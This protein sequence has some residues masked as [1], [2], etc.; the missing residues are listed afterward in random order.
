MPP[1]RNPIASLPY[2]AKNS[3][4]KSPEPF[5]GRRFCL[6]LLKKPDDLCGS[7]L[8]PQRHRSSEKNIPQ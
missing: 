6:A 1:H 4:K 5:F 8:Q 2:E 3:Q 7:L